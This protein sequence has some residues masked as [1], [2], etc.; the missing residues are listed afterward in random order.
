[1]KWVV[2]DAKVI[3]LNSESLEEHRGVDVNHVS[4]CVGEY[5]DDRGEAPI[6][7]PLEEA[8]LGAVSGAVYISACLAEPVPMEMMR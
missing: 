3:L 6:V 5:V 7:E 1:M 8:P 2:L 4:T